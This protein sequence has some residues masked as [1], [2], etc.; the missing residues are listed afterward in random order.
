M[1]VVF[2]KTVSNA[3][4]GRKR[5][6]EPGTRAEW[7]AVPVI[8]RKIFLMPVLAAII[9]LPAPPAY[10]PVLYFKSSLAV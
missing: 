5:A 3:W 7:P 4:Q 10:H 8:R 6:G 9:P 1:L 2:F